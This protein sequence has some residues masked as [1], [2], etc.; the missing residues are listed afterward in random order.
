MKVYISIDMEGIGGVAA[1]ADTTLGAPHYE[2]CRRL[3]TS[4]C[5]AAIE[6]C[7]QAGAEEV[8]VNDSHGTMLNLLQ[9]ELDARA[10]VVRGRAK[11]LGMVHGLDLGFDAAMFVGY[12]A[13]A[14]GA[15]G[16]LNHTMRGHDLCDVYLNTTPAGEVLLNAAMAGAFGVPVVLVSGDDVVCAEARAVLGDVETI[17]VKT[18]IDKYAALSVHP[19]VARQRIQEGAARALGR[20][21]DFIPFRLE[22]PATIRVSWN[23]TSTAALCANIPG[24]RRVAPREVVYNSDDMPTLYRLLRVLLSLGSAAQ[25]ASSYTYD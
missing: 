14:G 21:K 19:S 12:H 7:F 5:N 20:L 8:V 15:D 6:G 1:G 2:Y 18:A 10:R 23:S 9:E 3:M 24:V 11:A 17:E 25:V 16:V 4:E 22:V 13:R